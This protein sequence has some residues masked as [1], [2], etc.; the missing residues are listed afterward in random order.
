MEWTTADLASRD[1]FD[2]WRHALDETHL[3]WSL[4]NAASAQFAASLRML[5]IDGMR[6]VDCVC[7][8]CHGYRDTR[9][10]RRGDDGWFGVLMV[11]KG[12]E[13]VRQGDHSVELTPGTALIWDASKPIAFEVL[14]PLEKCTLLVSR[15]MLK[16]ETGLSELPLGKLDSSRGFG[17]LL[18]GRVSGLGRFMQDLSEGERVQLGHGLLM[19]LAQALEGVVGPSAVSPRI[20]LVQRIHRIIDLNF[21]DPDLDPKSVAE[22]AGISIRYLHQV[23]QEAGETAG[24]RILRRRLEGM[25]KALADPAYARMSITQIG[26][27][28]GF[29]SAAHISRS[30]RE[31]YGISPSEF[32]GQAIEDSDRQQRLGRDR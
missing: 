19:D 20:Q 24:S 10:I 12:R 18:H 4:A 1:R 31:R 13:R 9:D 5:D 7:D 30:F 27:A 25:R 8:P 2:A 21:P 28:F 15:G 22:R 6:I 3:P 17:A 14:E 26:F 23:L 16:S 29:S 32:R 11:R